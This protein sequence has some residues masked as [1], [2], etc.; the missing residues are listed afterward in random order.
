MMSPDSVVLDIF[1]VRLP[2]D[3]PDFD[4]RLWEQL[5]EQ[6]MKPEYRYSLLTNGIRAGRSDGMI[7]G[8]IAELLQL[9]NK[10]VSDGDLASM[11]LE[12]IS[13]KS[14]L[15]HRHLQ[16]RFGHRGEIV[17]TEQYDQLPLVT[18]DDSGRISGKTF[19]KAQPVF[20]IFAKSVPDGRVELSL[21][22]EIQFGQSRQRWGSTHGIMRLETGRDSKKFTEQQIISTL[23]A[24]EMLVISDMT[25]RPGSLGH[26]FF[27]EPDET[28][29]PGRKLLIIR[30]SQTQHDDINGIATVGD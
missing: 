28:G 27:H 15:M 7:S 10:Q 29:D 17:A 1:F 8:P 26:Y 11:P 3:D 6:S 9:D 2:E 12:A 13:E 21:T 22:P 4:T 20:E 30:L 16:L 14:G 5:D 24:G 23:S 25:T 18:V 19:C